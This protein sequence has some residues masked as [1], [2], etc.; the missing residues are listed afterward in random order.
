[1]N[2]IVV[3]VIGELSNK[4]DPSRKFVQTFVLAEQPNGYFVLNDIFRYLNDYDDEVEDEPEP[5][6]VLEEPTV[7]TVPQV[8]KTHEVVADEEI[9][10]TVDAKLE[11]VA[12]QE[13]PN[14]N[15]S[16][17]KEPEAEAEAEPAPEPQPVKVDDPPVTAEIPP[18]PEPTPAQSP[19]KAT[20]AA[21]VE[22]PPAKKTWANVIGSKASA[23]P[24]PPPTVPAQP[25]A[26]KAP[27]PQVTAPQAPMDSIPSPASSG[28]GWQTADH[29]KK[30]NRPQ[31]RTEQ[32]LAYVKN[33]TNKVD[34]PLLRTALEKFG[35]L[36]Y[37]DVS[38]SKA[39]FPSSANNYSN[40]I[41]ELRF[42]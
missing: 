42:R 23:T 27:T 15:G 6:P 2:N 10:Q 38:R 7:E 34:E 29:G 36:K 11:E 31:Q 22:A 20:P 17:I 18:E 14:L 35:T 40:R 32:H 37:F 41:L 21:P 24:T 3:Q 28:S 30:Q 5:E 1:M 26:Q 9:A 39:G 13:A 25:K 19:P 4:G 33:V 8:E 16:E 12:E